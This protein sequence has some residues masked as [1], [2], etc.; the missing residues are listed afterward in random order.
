MNT[1]VL[2]IGGG[3]LQNKDC[4]DRVVKIVKEKREAGKEIII[5][6]S[7]L[8]GVTDYLIDSMQ[9]SFDSPEKV[10]SIIQELKKK[11]FKYLDFIDNKKIKEQAMFEI[12]DKISVL[13]KFF[14][15]ISY[16][17]E[18]S[19]RSRDMIQS[20]GERLS[21]IVLEA[22]L[23]D[24]GI[25]AK[26]IDAQE[27]GIT[28]EGN[29]EKASTNME[30]TSE[31][32]KRLKKELTK[33][34]LLLPGYYGIDENGD[35]KTFGRGG[36]D[37]SAGFIANIYGAKLEI[38][39][40]VSGFMSAD[41]KLV[42]NAIQIDCLSYEEAE[43]L[44]Y[45]GAKILHPRTMAPLQE[46]QLKAEIKNLF[47]PTKKGTI[48]GQGCLTNKP[49]SITSTNVTI[50]NIATP[51]MVN[52]AGFSGKLFSILRDNNI[53]VDLI[54]TSET[55]ISFSINPKDTQR[56]LNELNILKNCKI[57]AFENLSLIGVVGEGLRNS[58]GLAGKLFTAVAQEGINIE[59]I[60]QGASEINISFVVNKNMCDKTIQAVHEKIIA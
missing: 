24:N 41:P 7:A 40:D 5:V 19:P 31:N 13:E 28:S 27:A 34:V 16:L 58:V 26:F 14:Y 38:W 18:I 35:I 4:F 54:S 57:K 55:A 43:E 60:T 59:L 25:D 15:G 37:Y 51:N 45:L 50:I 56:T 42:K 44:G 32:L 33:K 17:K 49:K 11:H 21:P 47:D 9:H 53:T 46:K 39:K 20:F 3:I 10:D 29:F 22:F 2:K 23:K 30:K 52:S 48:I 1:E 12:N 6:Q 8:Y 36:T